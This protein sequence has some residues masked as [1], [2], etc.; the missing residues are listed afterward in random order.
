MTSP[1][2][3]PFREPL[4]FS[5]LI[6]SVDDRSLL[7]KDGSDLAFRLV[8]RAGTVSGGPLDGTNMVEWGMH[9]IAPAYGEGRGFLLFE[10]PAGDEAYFRFEWTA[11]GV[12][13]PSGDIQPVMYGS[14][15]AHGGSGRF[16][17]IAGAGTV[18]IAIPSEE[19]RHWQ[20]SGALSL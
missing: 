5:A 3:L 11:R 15:A 8:Q 10:H 14:W 18:D 12:I 4:S 9:E 16:Q 13:V 6:S 19:S 20:F 17:N 2:N 7:L 1:A